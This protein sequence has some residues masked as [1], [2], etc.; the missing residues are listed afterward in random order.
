MRGILAN[1]IKQLAPLGIL[2]LIVVLA[3]SA[4]LFGNEPSFLFFENTT[5]WRLKNSNLHSLFLTGLIFTVS[6]LAISRDT[7]TTNYFN[8]FCLFFT[9]LYLAVMWDPGLGCMLML[10]SSIFRIKKEANHKSNA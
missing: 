2:I 1:R 6:V 4:F 5:L 9:G 8:F 3:N 10:L 7:K